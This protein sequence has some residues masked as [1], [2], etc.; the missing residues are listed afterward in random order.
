MVALC[1][2]SYVVFDEEQNTLKFSSKGVQK[3]TMYQLGKELTKEE[4]Y[5]SQNTYKNVFKVYEDQL[6]K[7]IN[8]ANYQ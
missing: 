4:D 2:K 5:D 1:A 6:Q 3:S 8:K 7:D